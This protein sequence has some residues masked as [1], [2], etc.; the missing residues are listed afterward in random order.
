MAAELNII[1]GA[2]LFCDEDPDESNHL[3]LSEV[4]LPDLTRTLEDH[5]P[6]GGF[7]AIGL[8][9]NMLEALTLPFKLI[10]INIGMLQRAGYG[11]GIVHNY[12]I[13]KEIRDVATQEK[14]RLTCVVKGII[15]T[16]SQE[17]YAKNLSGFNYEIQSI[18]SYR[19][20]LG[21]AV[22]YDFDF[23]SNR[24]R[25]GDNDQNSRTNAILGIV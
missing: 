15:G 6:G 12:T 4:G 21:E 8:D 3:Q 5:M 24:K 13:F 25:V 10:G 11:D 2:N 17:A 7:M 16:A 1:T 14:T 23:I 22:I 9:M 19:L 20:T 18:L